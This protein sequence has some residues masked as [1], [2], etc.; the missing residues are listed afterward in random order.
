AS[1]QES[2]AFHASIDEGSPSNAGL[3]HPVPA[4][5]GIAPASASGS[6]VPLATNSRYRPTVT[7]YLSMRTPEIDTA[8]SGRSM[9]SASG[10]QAEAPALAPEPIMKD[11]PVPAGNSRLEQRLSP[12]QGSRPTQERA[13]Q[14][15]SVQTRDAQSDE[16]L[17]RKPSSQRVG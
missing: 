2:S 7:S 12:L 9:P 1:W 15:P 6:H 16:I 10:W 11:A 14:E 8:V 3:C 4:T 17:E 13:P 5:P